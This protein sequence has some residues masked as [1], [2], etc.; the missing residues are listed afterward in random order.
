MRPPTNSSYTMWPLTSSQ[1]SFPATS[2]PIHSIPSCIS[3]QC[4]WRVPGPFL[5][6]GLC[7]CCVHCL[8][9]YSSRCRHDSDLRFIRVSAQ[10]LSPPESFP[11][12][13]I[14]HFLLPHFVFVLFCFFPYT[15]QSDI[16]FCLSGL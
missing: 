9:C 2:F 4:S 8:E 13:P 14:Y 7:M 11:D 5:P 6:Q 15:K 16:I 12:H 3:S 1:A 10:V